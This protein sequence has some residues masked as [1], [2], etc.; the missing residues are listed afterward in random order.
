MTRCL[1]CVLKSNVFTLQVDGTH[2]SALYVDGS[3][4]NGSIVDLKSFGNWYGIAPGITTAS[5]CSTGLVLG[6]N[7]FTSIGDTY[8]GGPGHNGLCLGSSTTNQNVT[9][10]EVVSTYFCQAGLAISDIDL[11]LDDCR[12]CNSLNPHFGSSSYGLELKG[13]QSWGRMDG[14]TFK[15]GTELPNILVSSPEFKFGRQSLLNVYMRTINSGTVTINSGSNTATITHGLWTTPTVESFQISPTNAS[16]YNKLWYISGCNAT[17][18]T[19]TID[20]AASGNA[21]FRWKTDISQ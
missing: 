12:G 16:A 1:Y 13:S 10:A 8:I 2:P 14:A 21:T 4:P 11:Q 17:T 15:T 5:V 6:I 3:A 18:C 19:L 20:S 7:G 9:N